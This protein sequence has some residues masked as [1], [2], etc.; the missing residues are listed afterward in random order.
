MAEKEKEIIAEEEESTPK[1]V[2]GFVSNNNK[3]ADGQ[4]ISVAAGNSHTHFLD[5]YGNVFMTG[6][7]RDAKASQFHEVCSPADSPCGPTFTPV[8][9][10]G[11]QN[12][13]NTYSGPGAD[14]NVAMLSDRSLVTWGKMIFAD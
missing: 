8:H 13:M 6:M 1:I 5:R 4:M 14:F 12:V 11:L 9:V 7:Y 3:N 10:A 2:T